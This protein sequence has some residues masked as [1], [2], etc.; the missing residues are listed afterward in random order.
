[1]TE[2]CIVMYN[3]VF[4]RC[5]RLQGCVECMSRT[6]R[7]LRRNV[8]SSISMLNKIDMYLVSFACDC[9]ACLSFSHVLIAHK[10]IS[11]YIRLARSPPSLL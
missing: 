5:R 6:T 2:K 7:E 11:L 9:R 1:M 10:K 4:R 8:L 3:D